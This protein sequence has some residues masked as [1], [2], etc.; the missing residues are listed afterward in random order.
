MKLG[1]FLLHKTNAGELCVIT[2]AGWLVATF[3][4]DHED[5]FCRNMPTE[6]ANKKIIHEYWG[7][8][9]IVNENNNPVKIPCHFIDL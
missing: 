9:T 7:D 6:M 2:E 4:I 5:L 1:D 3:W 8:L